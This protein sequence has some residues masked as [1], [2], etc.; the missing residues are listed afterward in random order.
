MDTARSSSR[1]GIVPSSLFGAI[2]RGVIAVNLI[3]VSLSWWPWFEGTATKPGEVDRLLSSVRLGGFRADFVWLMISTLFIFLAVFFFL[4]DARRSGS[5][6]ITTALC[7][8][9]ILAFCSFVYRAL[10]S[11]LLDFG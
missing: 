2:I 9:E 5:A 10:T 6:R 11:G 3:M 8:L 7:V 4:K 1:D